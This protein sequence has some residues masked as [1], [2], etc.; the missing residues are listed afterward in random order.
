MV[1]S[2]RKGGVRLAHVG[3]FAYESLIDFVSARVGLRPFDD[4]QWVD[5]FVLLDNEFFLGS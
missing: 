3:P 1:Y 4:R 2:I 5:D